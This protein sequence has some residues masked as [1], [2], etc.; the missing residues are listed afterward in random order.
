MKLFDRGNP[1]RKSSG[2]PPSLGVGDR[3]RAKDSFESCAAMKYY[4]H[5]YVEGELDPLRTAQLCEHLDRCPSCRIDLG[6]LQEERL[7]IGEIAIE[8]PSLPTRFARKVTD[9]IRAE[10]IVQIQH[11]KAGSKAENKAASA[12]ARGL[13]GRL[14]PIAAFLAAAAMVLVYF[15]TRT[16][17][18]TVSRSPIV[19]KATPT[20]SQPPASLASLIPFPTSDGAA[21]DPYCI[22]EELVN[23]DDIPLFPGT[24][25]AREP[26]SDPG[27]FAI[28]ER[29]GVTWRIV[30]YRPSIPRA[31]YLGKRIY[32]AHSSMDDPCSSDPN[33]DGK[34]DISDVAFDWQQVW[35]SSGL[36]ESPVVERP[37]SEEDPCEEACIGVDV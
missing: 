2:W 33:A 16:E 36:P 32:G 29:G 20:P 31:V 14:G 12:V 1:T 28:R 30:R 10:K 17:V 15:G 7:W 26:L 4:L 37:Q 27:F 23:E 8:A 25:C 22:D 34:T 9:C 21:G 11:E 35:E 6:T 5:F 19:A 3:S 24:S 18:E 13:R